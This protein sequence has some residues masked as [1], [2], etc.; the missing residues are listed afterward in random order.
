[1][2]QLYKNI[3]SR[4]IELNMTQSDLAKKMGYAD[5]SM[6]AK[7][8]KGAVDLPQSKIVAFAEAL[9]TTPGELMGFDDFEDPTLQKRH[10]ELEDIKGILNAAGYTLFCESYDDDHFCIRNSRN[11]TVASFSD[12]ELLNRYSSLHKKGK[13]TAE[14]LISSEDIFFKY[15]ESLGYSIIRDDPEHKPFIRYNNEVIRIDN[16]TLNNI[17]T[18]IDTYAKMIA[19]SLLLKLQEKEI[20]EKRQEKERLAQHLLNAAHE[21]NPTPEQKA[22]ADS[23]MEDDSEWE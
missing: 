15:F 10:A 11:Q 19:D 14:L 7:I 4:R 2:L 16:T 17:R 1:M 5:K 21:D 13:V 3:K 9:Q 12:Y 22:A 20:H 8:E 23:I 6:I 18:Q